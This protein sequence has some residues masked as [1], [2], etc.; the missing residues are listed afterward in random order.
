[1]V[2]KLVVEGV[3]SQ[4][5]ESVVRCLVG[6]IDGVAAISLNGRI[7]GVEAGLDAD[8]EIDVA[9]ML[10]AAVRRRVPARSDSTD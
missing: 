2:V 8:T 3:L 4:S 1:V 7:G 10:T 6:R 5:L 9:V